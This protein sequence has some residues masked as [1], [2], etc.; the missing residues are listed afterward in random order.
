[1]TCMRQ[2]FKLFII[3]KLTFHKQCK[4]SVC[5]SGNMRAAPCDS[6]RL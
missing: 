3:S 1:M 4:M 2:Q 6:A 5:Y